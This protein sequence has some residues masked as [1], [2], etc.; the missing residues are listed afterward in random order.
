MNL[1]A[2]H[3]AVIA[4]IALAAVIAVAALVV[5][6]LIFK[7][8]KKTVADITIDNRE[9]VGENAKA[10]EGLIVLA[11]D[12]EELVKELKE[13]QE[14]LK[15]LIPSEDRKVIDYDKKI[16]NIIGDLRIALTKSDGEES[17][18]T[19]ELIK[20]IKLAVADRNTK[21]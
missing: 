2:L 10:V 16:K 21:L 9:L 5:V 17:K 11:G 3:P 6:V 13:V 19:E 12:N 8:P 14:Q 1:L 15:Y 4:I 7:R 20:D 18:K